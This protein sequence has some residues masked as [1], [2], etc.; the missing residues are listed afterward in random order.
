MTATAGAVLI[1]AVEGTALTSSEVEFFHRYQPA[2]LTLFGRNIAADH[3]VSLPELLR[4]LQATRPTGAPPLVVAIDQEGGRVRRLKD[5][6]PDDGPPS[7][8]CAGR[9]DSEALASIEH[10]GRALGARLARLGIN[11]NFAPVADVL[12]EP[13]NTAIGDRAFGTDA[14]AVTLR[15]GAFL[16]GQQASGVKG[17]L[18]HFPG[19]GGATVD[20]HL[21]AATVEASREVLESR[22]LAPFRVLLSQVPMVMVSHCLYPALDAFTPASRSAVIITELLRRELGFQG[23]VVSDD[24]NMGAVPQADQDWQEAII[25]AVAAGTDMMLVCRHLERCRLAHAGLAQAARRSRAFATRLEDAAARVTKLR[26][27][28]FV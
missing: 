9:I 11:V 17:C 10:I 21:A 20:T 8:F 3:D 1:C 2:G 5:P 18:K 15:A 25:A 24:M 12:S 27:S 23:V 19:Q 28:L 13:S 14:Q 26:Q 22:D 16:A 6:F 7:N 4:S